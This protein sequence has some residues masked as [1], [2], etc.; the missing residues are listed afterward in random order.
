M[1]FFLGLDAIHNSP[2]Y[3]FD[4]FKLIPSFNIDVYEKFPYDLGYKIYSGSAKADLLIL[5][6]EDLGR[7]VKPAMLNFLGIENFVLHSVNI[8]EE[9][10]YSEVYRI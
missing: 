6:L 3:W 1:E 5:R 2:E 4:A 9:K 8:G 10:E 7:C